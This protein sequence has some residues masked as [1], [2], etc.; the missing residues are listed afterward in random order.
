[1]YLYICAYHTCMYICI[2]VRKMSLC[3]RICTDIQKASHRRP[4]TVS[5]HT[6]QCVMCTCLCQRSFGL[7][8]VVI[9][10]FAQNET[11]WLK[12]L[13][14]LGQVCTADSGLCSS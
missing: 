3:V 5:A 9:E 10:C 1:M 14:L 11:F 2:Y 12:C 8:V 13:L 4:D 6:C 7:H